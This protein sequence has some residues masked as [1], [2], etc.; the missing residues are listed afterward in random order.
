VAGEPDEV[1]TVDTSAPSGAGVPESPPKQGR[2]RNS[3][4]DMTLSML[5]LVAV[6]LVLTAV[7]TGFSFHLGPADP[8]STGKVHTPQNPRQD[9]QSVAG[10]VSFPL[11]VPRVPKGWQANSFAKRNIASG[12]STV[13]DVYVGW[14]TGDGNYVRLDQT[15]AGVADVA[16]AELHES[17]ASGASGGLEGSA[18]A[19]RELGSKR[20]AG[21]TWTVYPAQRS[22]RTWVSDRGSGRIAITGSGTPA[23]FRTMAKAALRAPALGARR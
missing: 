22:E 14:V 13:P 1:G 9:L 7:T 11:R 23:Q 2:G 8:Q 16:K 18:G 17:G 15:K 6:V 5:V 21:A 10:E 4:R 3:V 20:V 12:A 19:P